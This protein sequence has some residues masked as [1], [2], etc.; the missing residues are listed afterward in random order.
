[1]NGSIIE[2]AMQSSECWVRTHTSFQRELN[3]WHLIACTID[4]NFLILYHNGQVADRRSLYDTKWDTY[5]IMKL[6]IQQTRRRHDH[7][8]TSVDDVRVY[9]R[10]LRADEVKYLYENGRTPL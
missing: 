4:N 2:A 9:N 10:A 5:S 3:R 7:T 8:E 6:I 1:V